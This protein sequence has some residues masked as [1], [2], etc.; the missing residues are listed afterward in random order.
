MLNPFYSE[1]ILYTDEYENEELISAKK[2]TT[3][4]EAIKYLKE[5]TNVYY[6]DYWNGSSWEYKKLKREEAE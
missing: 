1:T 3:K 2:F 6:L 5:N 4:E